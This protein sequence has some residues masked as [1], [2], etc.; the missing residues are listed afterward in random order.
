LIVI[1]I[2]SFGCNENKY[3]FSNGGDW[4]KRIV[5]QEYLKILRNHF[6]NPKEINDNDVMLN[7]KF[8]WDENQVNFHSDSLVKCDILL[9]K[10][11]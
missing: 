11:N 5:S 1:S 2:F 10:S 8:G 6:K 3:D 9:P 7:Y 4:S